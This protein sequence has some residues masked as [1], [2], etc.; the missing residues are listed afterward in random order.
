M[1]FAAQERGE[2]QA[3]AIEDEQVPDNDNK[4]ES[5]Y[6]ERKKVKVVEEEYPEEATTEDLTT[7]S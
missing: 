7:G 2:K 4:S 6:D 5:S 1:S 3:K